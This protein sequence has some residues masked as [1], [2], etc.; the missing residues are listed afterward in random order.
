MAKKF[1]QNWDSTRRP[2][3]TE[4]DLCIAF[5]RNCIFLAEMAIFGRKA[6]RPKLTKCGESVSAENWPKFRPKFPAVST[7]G[8]TLLKVWRL[9]PDVYCA[10]LTCS[11]W[12]AIPSFG[13]F[14][15]VTPGAMPPPCHQTCKCNTTLLLNASLW[16]LP[17]LR[18]Q[19]NF[20]AFM[21]LLLP[22]ATA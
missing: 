10:Y 6:E 11:L 20:L 21:V 12:A 17:S 13:R 4:F 16:C 15:G 9:V 22:N 5:G 19:T 7:F 18:L 3:M 8:R 14:T 2:R 1:D